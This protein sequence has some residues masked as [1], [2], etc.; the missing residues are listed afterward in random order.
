VSSGNVRN[1]SSSVAF[2]VT[3]ASK[4]GWTY[5]PGAN[6]DPNGNGT[7]IVVSQ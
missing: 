6:H 7:T 3:R 2:S 4:P 1:A 5:E